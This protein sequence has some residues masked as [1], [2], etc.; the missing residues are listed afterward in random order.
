MATSQLYQLYLD[1]RLHY[2]GDDDDK[3]KSRLR[4]LGG[5]QTIAVSISS[6]LTTLPWRWPRHS[7]IQPTP[8]RLHFL[9]GD[10]GTVVSGYLH[11][12]YT[13]LAM[14]TAQLYPASSILTTL[15][16]RWRRHSCIQPALSWLH[17]LGDGD[18]TAVSSQLYLDYT[19][20]AM[21]T[22]QL[23]PASYI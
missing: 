19:T 12:D 4:Y 21:A 17:Y 22:T 8:S 10:D 20:L 11:L 15:P 14:A 3:A 6:I 18:D 1:C 2:L 13:S 16:W 9:G 5:G 7:R 23:Y